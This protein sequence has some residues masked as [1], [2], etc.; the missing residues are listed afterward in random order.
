MIGD[1][2][3]ECFEWKKI[4]KAVVERFQSEVVDP[5]LRKVEAGVRNLSSN[6]DEEEQR[7]FISQLA[8][9]KRV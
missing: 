1:K 9:T 4:D 6:V 5:F 3:N 7:I 8:S 2:A